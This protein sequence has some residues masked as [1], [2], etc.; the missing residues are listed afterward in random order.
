MKERVP[1]LVKLKHELMAQ[2]PLS[3]FRGTRHRLMPLVNV[4][5]VEVGY[6]GEFA[7]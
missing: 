4:V 1:A 6:G 2:S 7:E 3:Y 5:S